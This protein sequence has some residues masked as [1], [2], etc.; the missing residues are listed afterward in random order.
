MKKQNPNWNHPL[1]LYFRKILLGTKRSQSQTL[2]ANFPLSLYLARHVPNREIPHA[3][4]P[5]ALWADDD[6]DDKL[7]SLNEA[8]DEDGDTAAAAAAD[9]FPERLSSWMTHRVIPFTVRTFMQCDIWATS[10][11]SR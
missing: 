9:H 10:T 3:S 4:N 1:Q 8:N 6:D 5:F 7:Q 11:H 2:S